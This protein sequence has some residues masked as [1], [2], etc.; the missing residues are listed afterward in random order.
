MPTM[1]EQIEQNVVESLN[2]DGRIKTADVHVTVDNSDVTLTGT[3]PTDRAHHVIIDDVWAVPGVTVI[4]DKLEI[5][6]SAVHEHSR[7][8]D[9]KSA[10]IESSGEGSGDQAI[11]DMVRAN[12]ARAA[13][14]DLDPNSI[15]IHVR[16]G[17]VT[18]TG[19]VSSWAAC[20]AAHKAACSTPGV[21][22]AHNGIVIGP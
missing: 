20:R 22:K 7:C 12:L 10:D 13:L 6:D 9:A 17:K 1:Q 4:I 18:L 3:A 16:N 15:S 11:A 8:A 2:H 21:V 14:M 5:H 19:F